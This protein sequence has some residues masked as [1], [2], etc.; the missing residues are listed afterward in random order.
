M[1]TPQKKD[2]FVRIDLTQ[3]QS[4]KVKKVTGKDAEA[5][6]LTVNELEERIAPMRMTF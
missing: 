3:Q 6:E 2:E 4:E 5:I 1:S